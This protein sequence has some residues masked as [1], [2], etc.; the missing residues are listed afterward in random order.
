MEYIYAMHTLGAAFYELRCDLLPVWGEG[1]S[2]AIAHEVLGHITGMNRMV[3]LQFK[4]RPLTLQQQEKFDSYKQKLLMGMPMQYVLETAWFAGK[5][6][7]VNEHVL[8]PR[9][10]TEEL[11]AWAV[12]FADQRSEIAVLDI[13][14]GSGCIGISLKLE[15]P[16]AMVTASDVSDGALQVAAE[17]AAKL[18]AEITFKQLDFLDAAAR[19]GLGNYDII[20]S[21]PPYIP[22][23]R[24]TDLDS[25][26]REY[27]PAIALFV[28]DN[29]PLIFYR[30]IAEF[31]K[32]HLAPGGAV[33][34]ELDAAYASVCRVLFERAGYKHVD[35]AKDA[36]G[37]WRML[38]AQL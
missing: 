31:G 18:G 27:E 37:H 21:N 33:F 15:M 4:E 17:N 38:K 30:A 9:P 6:F 10:E 2:Q 19:Q 8:I 11:V 13:G 25:N 1:E 20:V 32:G 23:D 22:L 16:T 34:C 35:L 26:V 5:A 12:Q 24:K 3:R 36:Y 14:T 7:K 29:D 28:P